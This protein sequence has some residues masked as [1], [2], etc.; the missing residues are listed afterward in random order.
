M[1]QSTK[2][3]PLILAKVL[4]QVERAERLLELAPPDRLD[5]RPEALDGEGRP[6]WSLAQL[7]AHLAEA[8]AGFCAAL[9]GAYPER[10]AHFQQLRGMPREH[11]S[12]I[13]ET[14]RRLR[15]YRERIEEG[16]ALVTD[17]DLAR[18]V[19]TVFVPQGETVLTLLLGNLEHFINHKYQVFTYLKRMGVGV[20]SQDLYHWR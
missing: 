10:L 15:L 17:E 8:L 20:E 3:G 4:E 18:L 11:Q 13:E 6:A 14:R 9:H 12:A 1:G 16:F 5:W 19:P 2:L 7:L